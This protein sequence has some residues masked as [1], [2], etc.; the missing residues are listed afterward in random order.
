MLTTR[1]GALFGK[2]AA[3]FGV[4]APE[5]RL[6]AGARLHTVGIVRPARA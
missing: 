1:G 2:S 6:S 4:R 3:T 5:A